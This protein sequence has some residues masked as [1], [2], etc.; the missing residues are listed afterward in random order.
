MSATR[1]LAARPLNRLKA[2]RPVRGGTMLSGDPYV[3]NGVE[4]GL[5]GFVMS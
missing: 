2:V 3:W 5:S 1:S 4:S